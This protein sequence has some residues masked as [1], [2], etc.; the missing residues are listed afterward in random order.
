METDEGRFN[1]CWKSRSGTHTFLHPGRFPMILISEI[2][3]LEKSRDTFDY[4]TVIGARAEI[5]YEKNCTDIYNTDFFSN[6]INSAYHRW[7]Y[8]GSV[9]SEAE[10]FNY[11][12]SELGVHEVILEVGSE[13]QACAEHRDTAYIYVTEPISEFTIDKH[14]CVGEPILL[15]ASASSQFPESCSNIYN[16]EFEGLRPISTA[17]LTSHQI[18]QPG[19]QEVKLTV[20]DVNG[21]STTSVQTINVYGTY[22]DFPLDTSVCLPH[23]V[24]FENNTQADTTIVSWEWSFGSDER[25]PEYTFTEPNVPRSSPSESDTISVSLRTVDA[26]GCTDTFELK[27]RVFYPDSHWSNFFPREVCLG[28]RVNLKVIT[29]NHD[30]KPLEYTWSLD[31]N[32]GPITSS[33]SIQPVTFNDTGEQHIWVDRTVV[34]TLCTERLEIDITV[35]AL[36]DA[37]FDTSVDSLDFICFP[38]TVQFQN[39][40]VTDGTVDYEWDFGEGSTS[41]I[42]NPAITYQRGTFEAELTATSRFGCEDTK[43]QLITLIGPDGDLVIDDKDLCL[44]EVAEINLANPVDVETFTW[45]LGDG[46]II[47]NENSI[48][49]TYEFIPPLGSHNISLILQSA[50]SSC[51]TILSEE[52]NIHPVPEVAFETSED[53]DELICYPATIRF[54]NISDNIGNVAYTW[55]LGNGTQT[56][57][58]NPIATYDKGD[59]TVNLEAESSFGCKADLDQSFTVVGPE[60]SLIADEVSLCVGDTIQFSLIHTIDVGQ[61]NWNLGDGTEFIDSLDL[62]YIYEG[63]AGSNQNT[64]NVTLVSG[65]NGCEHSLEIDVIVHGV[66]ADFEVD[67]SFDYCQGFVRL[68]N[69]SESASVYFWEFGDGNTSTEENPSHKYEDDGFT[70]VTLTAENPEAGCSDI[71]TKDIQITPENIFYDFA[72]VFSP[73][74]DGRN[75]YFRAVI[76]ER[77]KE[78]V[79]TSVFKVYDKWGQLIYDNTNS[80]GWDGTFKGQQLPPDVYAYFLE[81]DIENCKVV[82]EKGNV[83]LIR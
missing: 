52:I 57:T 7:L 51:E 6:S 27:T 15:D 61:I 49:H 41:V 12:F 67:E 74:F 72:N 78:F 48:V 4:I 9:I 42:E 50:E 26:L 59:Y 79:S 25:E 10:N 55:N 29:D 54:E 64:V 66:I 37:N 70:K 77:Y 76:P 20:V 69:Q 34:G 63:E 62:A 73:N 53:I 56:S 40:S 47:S 28:D 58:G 39:T 24:I 17:D 2:E 21:C 23:Q 3:G 32:E 30:F 45:D 35:R 18:F 19:R 46:T 80:E 14:V 31:P 36:P 8:N 81:V 43:T 75:D 60:A 33:S 13:D 68:I 83:T 11:R 71:I 16:W 1:H 22:I 38:H 82:Q 65:E 5:G 44:G